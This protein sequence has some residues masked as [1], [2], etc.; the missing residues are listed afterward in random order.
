M[1]R[2]ERNEM[3][4]IVLFHHVMGPTDGIGDLAD[5]WSA[6]GHQVHTPDLFDGARFESIDDGIA[7]LESIGFP[8]LLER[9]Q[10]AVSELSE[11]LVYAG[12]S[13]GVIA[14]QFLA[15]TRPEAVGAV[16]MESCLAV[17]EFGDG[18]PAG[19]PVQ[20]HGMSDDPFFA[21]E[22]DI[23]NAREIVA[24]SPPGSA[25]LF[26]YPGDR[27]LFVDSSLPVH[28]AAATRLVIERTLG[29]LAATDGAN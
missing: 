2:A 8:T 26:E 14:A 9:A 3:A 27:H 22:G 28:D 29:F 23:D 10:A 5:E 12:V 17:T 13:M 4:E 20:I 16:L 11:S 7:H 21:G 24:G 6:A 18:W 1:L 19:V 25:E 15:Q